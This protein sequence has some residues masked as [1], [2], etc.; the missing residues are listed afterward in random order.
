MNN[1]IAFNIITILT[2]F[3]DP[4]VVLPAIYMIGLQGTLLEVIGGLVDIPTLLNRAEAAFK[5]Q[6]EQ[7]NV[8]PSAQVFIFMYVT[9]SLD[10]YFIKFV[11]NLH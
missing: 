1:F 5:V 2:N 3:L 6:N 10:C 7:Q 9:V 4:L 11:F 8:A